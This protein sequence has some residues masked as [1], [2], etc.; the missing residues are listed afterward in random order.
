[1]VYVHIPFC[2]SHCT[3]CGFYSEL[4][5]LGDEGSEFVDALCREIALTDS[6]FAAGS[7]QT[8]YF[9]GGT[10]S[11][12][13]A[14]SLGSI[15]GA[16]AAKGLYDRDE[17]VE[18][19]ME[20]NPDDIVRKGAVYLDK[21]RR[22]GVNRV[23]MGV[24][25]F[26]DAVLRRMG[27]RHNA[28]E[29]VKAYEM[30]HKAGFDNIS[31]DLIIGFSDR[32]DPSSVRASLCSLSCLPQ[33][34]SCYELS[35]ESG[36][37]LEKMLAKGLFSLPD[38]EECAAQYEALCALLQD[39]GY[40]HY[41]I[42]NWA[43]GP[44]R[45]RHNSS[46]WTHAPY[47]GFGPGAHSF[48]GRRRYWNTPDLKAYIDAADKGDFFPVRGEEALTEE[49]IL[50]EE[51]MLGLR[52]SDGIPPE[53]L[54]PKK[55]RAAMESGLLTASKT[56]QGNVCISEGSWIVSDDVIAGLV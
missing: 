17:C 40:E 51:I 29:A 38:E 53:I 3:Y 41:E 32:F 34:V 8:L 14:E 45:S 23:S 36:S 2:R 24:Q 7:V 42:S 10:P 22:A 11:L 39:L 16:L 49:Q 54:H 13:D 20:V 44:H 50:E 48:D 37:G 1:M 56:L 47:I 15:V 21:L 30:L 28:E 6:G 12:L 43:L 35:I 4:F 26:D 9:G 25:S 18:F 27:R 46:Y 5:R 52:T 19:T 31:I 33:H 55:Y